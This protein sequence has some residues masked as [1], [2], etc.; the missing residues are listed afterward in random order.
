[1]TLQ[2]TRDGIVA[3]DDAVRA[4]Y[5]QHQT[6]YQRAESV[7]IEDLLAPVNQDQSTTVSQA[8]MDGIQRDIGKEIPRVEMVAHTILSLLQTALVRRLVDPSTDLDLV[9]DDMRRTI[10]LIVADRINNPEIYNRPASSP[11]PT[12][13]QINA[14]TV[15]SGPSI[16]LRQYVAV[17]LPIQPTTGVSSWAVGRSGGR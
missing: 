11:T 6:D 4:F 14:A 15:E 1:M 10:I 2:E 7:R 9:F 5:D 17:G 3:G 12:E 13:S 8:L 16:A